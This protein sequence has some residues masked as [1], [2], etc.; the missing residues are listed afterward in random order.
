MAS[1][2][3]INSDKG[4]GPYAALSQATV[5]N[6]LVF[7]SG[8]LGVDPVTMEM[9]EGN[10]ANRTTRALEN[11]KIILEEAGSGVDKVLKVNIF[12]TSISDVAEL[13]KAYNGVQA[14]YNY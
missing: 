10:I 7:C 9:V 2:I 4:P 3:Y 8:A 5:F 12:V 6:G 1:H 11:I 13:N 14:K